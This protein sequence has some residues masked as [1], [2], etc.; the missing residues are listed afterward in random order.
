[1]T[2]IEVL[3]KWLPMIAYILN[4]ALFGEKHIDI[5]NNLLSPAADLRTSAKV[6]HLLDRPL[7]G[8]ESRGGGD[9]GRRGGGVDSLVVQRRKVVEVVAAAAAPVGLIA[10]SV[11]GDA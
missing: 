5:R 2:I 11:V 8:E 7:K 9:R 1:M 4:S 3:F 6:S 10:V